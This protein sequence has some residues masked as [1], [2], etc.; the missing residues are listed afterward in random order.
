MNHRRWYATGTT[1][2]DGRVLVSSGYDQDATDLVTTPEVYDVDRHRWTD[3][4]AAT[5]AQ[6]VY[7]FQYQLP[8]GRVLWAGASEVATA[9]EVARRR[10]PDLDHDRRPRHRRRE[11]RQLRARQVHQGRLGRRQRRGG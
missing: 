1:L 2:G 3:L 11:H 4:P 7:P 6:P 8:D 10:H 9:T 5:Q